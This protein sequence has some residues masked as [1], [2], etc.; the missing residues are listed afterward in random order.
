MLRH[1]S[2]SVL[3]L[4]AALALAP[5][6]AAAANFGPIAEDDTFFDV[7]I[8]QRKVRLEVFI[9]RPKDAGGRLPVAL[10]THGKATS[11][12]R[13]A[14][15]R[16]FRYRFIARDLARRG[17]LTVVVI[18]RGF[19]RSDGPF[20]YPMSCYATVMA[21]RFETAADDLQAA[22]AQVLRRPDADPGRIIAIGASTGGMA[23]MALGARN[24][25]GLRAV[26]NVSGGLRFE[27]CPKEKLLIETTR[28]L[29]SRSRVPNAWFYAE[30]DS[31]FPPAIAGRMHRAFTGAG[32]K[33]EL[34]TF[35]ALPRD[36]HL[37]FTGRAGRGAW[38]PRFD[39]YLKGQGLPAFEPADAERLL[40]T[41]ALPAT[42]AALVERYLS[43][44][45]EKALIYSD[46]AQ[47][48]F[49]V[50]AATDPAR[51][52]AEAMALCKARTSAED[53]RPVLE[54]LARPQATTVQTSPESGPDKRSGSPPDRDALARRLNISAKARGF[55][56]SYL[57]RENHKALARSIRREFYSFTAANPSAAVA[58]ER[59]L[60]RCAQRAGTPCIIIM[61]DDRPVLR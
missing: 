27:K 21:P 26:V 11:Q 19:G 41:S 48:G 31:F 28:A 59:T 49:F 43:A 38:L 44:P 25:P 50:G 14:A 60:A 42:Q 34:H 16:A 47:R 33:A 57:K 23:V 29:G 53:C 8:G 35:A 10:V 7:T 4:C 20:P 30:N 9:A 36:G 37:L 3:W 15:L 45:G 56:D 39:A 61:E 12:R 24:P 1:L 17:Y 22:L 52:R 32:G 58:R 46:L 2:A 54:N 13:M 18:R 40:Q 51:A 6:A 5:P 55:F